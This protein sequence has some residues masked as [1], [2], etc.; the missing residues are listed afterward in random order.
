MIEIQILLTLW[1]SD[2]KNKQ[3]LTNKTEWMDGDR[4]PEMKVN[5]FT[6]HPQQAVIH[7]CFHGPCNCKSQK[8]CCSRP[9]TKKWSYVS[10]VQH[11]LSTISTASKLPNHLNSKG[12]YS[13]ILFCPI[14]PFEIIFIGKL[15][16]N[17]FKLVCLQN[18]VW[19]RNEIQKSFLQSSWDIP[20]QFSHTQTW[21]N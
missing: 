16:L 13:T 3:T 8:V 6:P 20:L 10:S 9:R 12:A 1:K 5:V 7:K 15:P 11:L 18:I 14:S 19:S 21:V 17:G 2:F 4:I